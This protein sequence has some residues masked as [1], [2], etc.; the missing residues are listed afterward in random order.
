MENVATLLLTARHANE[1]S[2]REATEQQTIIISFIQIL[3]TL[4]EKTYFCLV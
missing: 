4:L 3:P 1:K 2:A